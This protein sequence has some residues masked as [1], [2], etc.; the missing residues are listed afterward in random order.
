MC[1][2]FMTLVPIEVKK[3]KKLLVIPK[4]RSTS[5]IGV[6]RPLYIFTDPCAPKPREANR[7]LMTDATRAEAYTLPMM[8]LSDTS[9]RSCLPVR[10]AFLFGN[11]CSGSQSH[12]DKDLQLSADNVMNFPVHM[13]CRSM[14]LDLT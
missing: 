8:Q 2:T 1:Y 3:K 4:Q 9:L 5:T 13:V 14:R 12:S 7:K 10:F 11:I 6:Q